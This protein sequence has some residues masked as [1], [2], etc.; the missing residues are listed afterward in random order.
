MSQ[1][2]LI[3]TSKVKEFSDTLL[4]DPPSLLL[5]LVYSSRPS[6]R[7]FLF[8][9][10]I[11]LAICANVLRVAGTAILADHH[12]ELAMGYYHLFAGWLVFL[13]GVCRGQMKSS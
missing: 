5:G 11:P 8:A 7:A 13:L 2:C 6:A 12:Q 4:A 1:L 10:S 9:A 3:P